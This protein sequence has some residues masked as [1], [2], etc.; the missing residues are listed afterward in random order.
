MDWFV[1]VM[2]GEVN[3]YELVLFVAINNFLLRRF[4]RGPKG[5]KGEMGPMGMTGIMGRDGKDCRTNGETHKEAISQLEADFEILR[6]SEAFKRWQEK[7]DN[8]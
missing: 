7:R 6:N 3:W 1:E 4:I 2:S 5:D 8:G